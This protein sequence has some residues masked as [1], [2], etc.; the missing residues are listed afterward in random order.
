[1]YHLGRLLSA[2]V[3]GPADP[4]RALRLLR[5]SADAGWPQAMHELGGLYLRG[6]L[7]RRD[8]VQARRW[9]RAAAA[10]G[11]RPAQQALDALDG[12]R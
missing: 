8:L 7:G 5:R 9:Y 11:F 1:M 4:D 10:K 2:G 12:R 6:E 3:G